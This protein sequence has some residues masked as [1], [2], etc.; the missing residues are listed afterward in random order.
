MDDDL[1]GDHRENDEQSPPGDFLDIL[2]AWDAEPVEPEME[3]D[4]ELERMRLRR[5]AWIKP[6]ALIVAIAML[7]L[8]APS[9]VRFLERLFGH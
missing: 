5:D 2:D 7:A 3:P 6:T 1:T 4:P 8:A 9:V